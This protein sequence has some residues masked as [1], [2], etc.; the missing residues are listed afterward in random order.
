VNTCQRAGFPATIRNDAGSGAG[1]RLSRAHPISPFGRKPLRRLRDEAKFLMGLS[2]VERT[3][4][5]CWTLFE[6]LILVVSHNGPTMFARIEMTRAAEPR[7]V[8]NWCRQRAKAY[9][10]RVRCL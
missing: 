6:A 7:E 4:P 9:K 3:Q 5:I 8:R 1:E 2:R 10:L